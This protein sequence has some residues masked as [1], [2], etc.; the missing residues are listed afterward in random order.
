[1]NEMETSRKTHLVAD[2]ETGL[3]SLESCELSCITYSC[4][5]KYHEGVNDWLPIII[6]NIIPKRL[7]STTFFC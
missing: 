2:M 3:D 4:I 5:R 6:T 1:M 7:F